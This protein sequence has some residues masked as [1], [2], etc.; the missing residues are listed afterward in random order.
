MENALLRKRNFT[1]TKKPMSSF[2]SEVLD[3]LSQSNTDITEVTYVVPSRRVAVFL[4]KDIASRIHKPVFQP[5]ILSIEE[6]V[7]KLAGVSIMPDLDLLALFYKAYKRTTPAD[8]LETYDAFLNWAPTILKDFNELDRYLVPTEDF[9]TFLGNVKELEQWHWSLGKDQTPMITNY[10]KFWKRL[11]TYYDAFKELCMEEQ[12]VY[13]GLAYRTAFAKADSAKEIFKKPLVFMGLNALNTA[14]A[15]II[16]KLLEEQ[17][18]HIYWDTDRYFLDRPYHEAGKFIKEYREHWKYYQN[19]KT[20]FINDHFA[21]AKSMEIAGASGPLAMVQT[22]I[23]KLRGIPH[24]EHAETVIVLADEAL[25]IPLLNA[26]PEEI[27]R[28]NVTMGLGLEKL[29]ISAFIL[30]IIQIHTQFNEQGF[31]FKNVIK[32]LESSFSHYLLSQ[33]P[34]QYIKKIHRENLVHVV[35]LDLISGNVEDQFLNGLL[36]KNY[37]AEG[38][39]DFVD[40]TLATLRAKLSV[41]FDKQLELEQLLAMTEVLS[42]LKALIFSGEKI[43]DLRTIAYLLRQLLPLKKLDFIGEPVMGLQIMGLLETRGLDYKNVI[44]LSV[45]EG[46][47]PAGKTVASY[48]PFD[49]KRRFNLPTYSEKDSVYAYHFYRLLHR[50]KNAIFIYNT[51]PGKLGGGEKSRFLTQLMS[52]NKV[53]HDIQLNNYIYKNQPVGKQLVTINK[54]ASYFV[55]L[56]EIADKGFSPSALTSYVRNPLDFYA[57]KILRIAQVDEVEESIALNTMGSIIHEALD[58]LYRPYVMKILALGDFKEMKSRIEQQ[59][60]GA[61]KLYYPSRSLPVGRNKIIYEVSMYYV[62]MMVGQDENLVRDGNEL[63]IQSVERDLKATI[64]SR[65]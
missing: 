9:F 55:R 28:Y 15:G 46:V 36:E 37:T 23:K 51:E 10:L 14:E 6:F 16:Q 18:A 41:E 58:K 20:K 64:R 3:D 11:H 2:I 13:Q 24:S 63:I 38:F 42:N 49:M 26:I 27:D 17:Q 62:K 25:L 34:N 57:Q 48:I 8:E 54:V 61:Y 33:K 44:M 12:T 7:E 56:K 47:L 52:N 53:A 21:S 30:D 32:V 40:A 31:Y 43:T 19:E 59:V 5:Q 35:A 4:S 39:I 60:D 1:Q 65:E 29:P 45:N 50:V 22:A